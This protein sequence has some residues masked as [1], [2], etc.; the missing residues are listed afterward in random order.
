MLKAFSK[1]KVNRA[2]L[3]SWLAHNEKDQELLWS[4]KFFPKMK[5]TNAWAVIQPKNVKRKKTVWKILK[6]K[7]DL[8][9]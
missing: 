4:I 6:K 1:Q 9:F 8:N 5:L 3:T 2:N 7:T